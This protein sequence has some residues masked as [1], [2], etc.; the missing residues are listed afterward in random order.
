MKTNN[1]LEFHQLDALNHEELCIFLKDIGPDNIVKYIQGQ[2]SNKNIKSRILLKMRTNFINM[3]HDEKLQLIDIVAGL[4]EEREKSFCQFTINQIS[5]LGKAVYKLLDSI[6][7]CYETQYT[8]DSF[9]KFDLDDYM[10]F[11]ERVPPM[12]SH[13]FRIILVYLK[14]QH[15]DILEEAMLMA[16]VIQKYRHQVGKIRMEERDRS[17]K[18][19]E[20]MMKRM[21]KGY[22]EL[23]K[24]VK[25]LNSE[26]NEKNKKCTEL[27]DGYKHITKEK[28]DLNEDIIRIQAEKTELEN[29]AE[30]LKN[31]LSDVQS[32]SETEKQKL[33]KK[34]QEQNLK[35]NDLKKDKNT[36]KTE[37]K[38]L[39]D[40]KEAFTATF[41]EKKESF[42]KRL[43]GECKELVQKNEMLKLQISQQEEK[44][45]AL[46]SQND[47]LE[48]K[49]RAEKI[50]SS[51]A[52]NSFINTDILRQNRLFIEHS[53]QPDKNDILTV[54]SASG[55]ITYACLTM[56]SLIQ[57]PADKEWDTTCKNII[58]Y[59]ILSRA[60]KIAPLLCGYGSL[61]IA[62]A[63][64]AMSD[65]ENPDVISIEPGFHDIS[66]LDA[67]IM[68]SKTK[69]IIITDGFGHMN[70]D[71][72]LPI[73]RKK[74]DKHLIYIAEAPN[75]MHY[76]PSYI[77]RYLLLIAYSGK[78]LNFGYQHSYSILDY[79]L[80][81][82]SYNPDGYKRIFSNL[83]DLHLDAVYLSTRQELFN[84]ALNLN[85]S[86]SKKTFETYAQ[87]ELFWLL[88]D[89]KKMKLKECLEKMK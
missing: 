52:I 64:V 70:E 83:K 9:K 5:I 19:R 10:Q 50:N 53:E 36:L 62:K 89:E 67:N 57:N 81:K 13:D 1:S 23:K 55:F 47:A 68:D 14:T 63:L 60:L 75:E 29:T 3:S 24:T 26:L 61:Q 34:I 20:N 73:L 11:F 66:I 85:N 69:N 46:S 87:N 27:E 59:F 4:I 40:V 17:K 15:I 2:S 45:S 43:E 48:K 74:Y 35:I 65:G 80:K 31:T 7:E 30:Q 22:D 21:R 78:Q 72:L 76:V 25:D 77:W 49:S 82:L 44:L 56:K 38:K 12:L 6:N 86:D 32:Q 28:N 37:V 51:V 8:I 88:T 16:P 39:T 84:Y 58:T 71:T 18:A 33:C 54:K 79:D 41:N 42:E